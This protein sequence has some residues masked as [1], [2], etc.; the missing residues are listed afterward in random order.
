M[1][2][3][4]HINFLFASQTQSTLQVEQFV[5]SQEPMSNPADNKHNEESDDATVSQKQPLHD[6]D[7]EQINGISRV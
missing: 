4:S 5:E 6:N 2:G 7:S 1:I 3:V